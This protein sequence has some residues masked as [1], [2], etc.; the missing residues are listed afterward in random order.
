[1]LHHRSGTRKSITV[2][3]FQA[4]A[5]AGR[6]SNG[7][8]S[9]LLWLLLRLTHWTLILKTMSRIT[10]PS[11]ALAMQPPELH[12]YKCQWISFSGPDTVQYDVQSPGRYDSVKL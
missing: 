11:C 10:L 3:T 7:C 2:Q 4:S 1:M 8:W 5:L 6:S 9:C 12:G